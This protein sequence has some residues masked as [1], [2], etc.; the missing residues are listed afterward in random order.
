M[1][2]ILP[3]Y[4]GFPI[5]LLPVLQVA[6][7]LLIGVLDKDSQSHK[8][9]RNQNEGLAAGIRDRLYGLQNRDYQEVD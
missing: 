5:V 1:V 2:A 6:V 7:E 3:E 9:K 4:V 8:G